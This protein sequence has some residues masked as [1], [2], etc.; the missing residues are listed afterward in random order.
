MNSELAAWIKTKTSPS[1]VFL[2]PMWYTNR[3]FI[4]GRASYY[5]WPYYAWSAGHD[6]NKRDAI[7]LWLLSGC[8]NDPETF[9]NYCK[10]REIK[11]VVFD[12][13]FYSMYDEEGYPKVNA[14]FFMDN[15]KQVAYFP[16]DNDTI[17]YQVY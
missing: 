3:F 15:L 6:T 10:S 11:Y 7:Y 12:P 17:V 1:D 8:T 16:N 13:E 2:T 5:A 14:Q 9:V 4:A